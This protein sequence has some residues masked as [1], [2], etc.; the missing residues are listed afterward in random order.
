MSLDD[1]IGAGPDLSE[2]EAMRACAELEELLLTH[3][4]RIWPAHATDEQKQAAIDACIRG[5]E[6]RWYPPQ[7]RRRCWIW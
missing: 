5:A 3:G 2:A 7:R 6:P 4:W 1:L